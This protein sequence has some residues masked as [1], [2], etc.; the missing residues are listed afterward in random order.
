MVLRILHC[1]K[2]YMPDEIG[3]VAEAIS[4]VTSA[5]DPGFHHSILVGRPRG[6]GRD[7]VHEG[8]P[9]HAVTSVG[10]IASLP[11][12]PGYP[13]ALMRQARSADLIVHHSPFPLT[14]LGLLLGVSEKPALIVHWHA[15]LELSKIASL[16]VKPLLRSSLK[17]ADRIIVPHETVMH[18][19]PFLQ[20]FSEKCVVIPY[21]VDFDYWA[22]LN[23]EEQHKVAEIRREHPRLIVSTGRLVPY[24]GHRVLLHAMQQVDATLC[25]IGTGV[26]GQQLKTTVQELQLGHR[27]VLAGWQDR[28]QLKIMLHA[29]RVFAFSSL[30]SAESFGIAQ[31]EAMAAGL[32]VVNTALATAVPHVARHEIE[33]LTVPPGGADALASA[34]SRLLNNRT[35]AE[36]FGR[37]AQERVK[38]DFDR[39]IVVARTRQVY[40]ETMAPFATTSEGGRIIS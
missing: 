16:W 31:L 3:G 15:D 20:G 9:V 19:S 17:R 29:A 13:F 11:I 30:T 10:T 35:L 26:L 34:V 38:Q 28:Q 36:K 6:W 24:K 7:I 40:E 8:I 33:G 39:G 5:H 22:N 18:S 4:M 37:A 14:D 1:Y 2:S 32:P 12:A 27:V 25:I 23:A 21:G